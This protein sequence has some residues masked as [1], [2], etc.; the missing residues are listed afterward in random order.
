MLYTVELIKSKNVILHT[1]VFQNPLSSD[2]NQDTIKQYV[3]SATSNQANS[4]K[5]C[6]ANIPFTRS[7]GGH[8]CTSRC[9]P[10]TPCHISTRIPERVSRHHINATAPSSSYQT[11]RRH[12]GKNTHFILTLPLPHQSL[13]YFQ[14][15]DPFK[16]TSAILNSL[17]RDTPRNS[18]L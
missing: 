5:S 17:I 7:H 12:H 2:S 9:H 6:K 10:T 18:I 16:N 8:L 4:Y 3:T 15:A 11:T 14:M 13:R 1:S